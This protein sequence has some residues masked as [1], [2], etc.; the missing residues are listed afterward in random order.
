[1]NT[2]NNLV[3]NW[4]YPQG[5]TSYIKRDTI[6]WTLK[7]TQ[8]IIKEFVDI[9]PNKLSS[10]ISNQIREIILKKNDEFSPEDR[11]FIESLTIAEKGELNLA[12]F[13]SKQ[14]VWKPVQETLNLIRKE[15]SKIQWNQVVAK[16]PKNP[17]LL[18]KAA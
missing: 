9:S 12:L 15:K 1:M 13:F 11:K 2:R 17:Y 10:E 5:Y 7:D 3:S 14:W 18:N 6:N 16:H 4:E 8:K